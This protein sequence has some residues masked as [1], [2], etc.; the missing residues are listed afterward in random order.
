MKPII[1]QVAKAAKLISLPDTYLRLKKILDQPDFTMDEVA[2][3]ISQDP[4]MTVRLLRLVNSSFFGISARID[5]VSHAISMLGTQ[6]VHDLVL[7][8]SVARVFEGVS[9]EVADMRRFWRGSVYCGV[10]SRLLSA[11]CNV[12]DSER[13]FVTGLL[14]DIGHLIMYQAIPEQEQQAILEAGESGI[15]LYR[16]ERALFGFDYAKLGGVMIRQWGLPRSLWETTR[17]H[18]E[19][20]RSKDYSLTTC[21]VHIASLLTKARE[22]KGNFGEG[23]FEVDPVAW[24]VTGLTPEQCAKVREEAGLQVDGVISLIFSGLNA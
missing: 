19:P 12:L 8:T 16:V 13:L 7:A 22:N 10:A 5:T 15:P 9:T 11:Q 21:L 17:F 23:V 18:V 20:A 3:L 4:A 2:V 6:Q 14:H 1:E 24:S